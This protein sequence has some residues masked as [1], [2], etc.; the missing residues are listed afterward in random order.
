MTWGTRNG[1]LP[2]QT[3]AERLGDVL[4]VLREEARQRGNNA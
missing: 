1:W 4:M 3:K 2:S